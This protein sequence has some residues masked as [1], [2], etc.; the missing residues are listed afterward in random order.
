MIVYER[1]QLADD[2][3]VA[4]CGEIGLDAQLDR[5]ETQLLEAADLAARERLVLEVGQRW[6]PPERESA[7][8][9]FARFSG[10]TRSEMLPGLFEQP[11]EPLQ[12][13]RARRDAQLVAR[14]PRF[15][16]ALAKQLAKLGDE[17][18]DRLDGG[19]RRQ[20][21]PE[22]VNEPHRRHDPVR[23]QEQDSEQSA[24]LGSGERNLAT[25]LPDGEWPQDAE[26]QGKNV[27]PATGKL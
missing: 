22:F 12:V 8:E 19:R 3:G 16:Y 17:L 9:P 21:A 24:L 5:G 6:P 26:F 4:S 23:A 7:P 14:G 13:E 18:L 20:L 15:E 10:R 27:T 11:F 1:L 2:F 25:V